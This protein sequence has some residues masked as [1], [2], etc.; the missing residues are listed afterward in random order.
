MQIERMTSISE[1]LYDFYILDIDL[2]AFACL[3]DYGYSHVSGEEYDYCENKNINNLKK[4]L[5]FIEFKPSLITIAR[6]TFPDVYTPSHLVEELE[7]KTLKILKDV[8]Y[9]GF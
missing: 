8:Y 6:S 2:D 5:K 1:H 7:Q 9:E 3:E 4:V